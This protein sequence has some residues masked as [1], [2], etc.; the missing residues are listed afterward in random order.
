MKVIGIIFGILAALF[1]LWMGFG[2]VWWQNNHEEVKQLVDQALVEGEEI[3]R[4]S[5]DEE[6]LEIYLGVM[7]DCGEMTCTIQNQV[8]L[9]TCLEHSAPSATLCA[10]APAKDE[11]IDLASWATEI[12]QDHG[13]TNP[14]CAAGLQEV[15][16]YCVGSG[17]ES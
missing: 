13:V 5:T 15:A 7:K 4:D 11:L 12:C 8:F 16:L 2:F 9:K 14:N 10:A 1:I 6:C 17:P 3:G